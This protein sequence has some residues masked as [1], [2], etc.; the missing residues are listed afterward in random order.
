MQSSGANTVV[1][2]ADEL[3]DNDI[4][5]MQQN[6]SGVDGVV[7]ACVHERTRHL[8]VIDYDPR[9]VG[10]EQLLRRIRHNGLHA[11]LIGGI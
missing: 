4:S 1:H 3:S 8:W 2:V 10:S 5:D 11:E 9:Q 7:S 6:L